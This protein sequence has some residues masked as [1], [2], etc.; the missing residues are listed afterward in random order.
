MSRSVTKLFTTSGTW[1]VLQVLLLSLSLEGRFGGGVEVEAEAEV[2]LLSGARGGGAG[3][4]G[5]SVPS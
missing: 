3:G 1:T 4:S 5:G 2:P